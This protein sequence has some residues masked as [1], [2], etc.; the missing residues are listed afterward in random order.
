MKAQ[1]GDWIQMP[2]A[3]GLHTAILNRLRRAVDEGEL[4][5]EA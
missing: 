4:P 1:A 3:S 2:L 5:A